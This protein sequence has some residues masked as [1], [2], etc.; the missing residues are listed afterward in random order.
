MSRT[1]PVPNAHGKIRQRPNSRALSRTEPLAGKNL[2]TVLCVLLAG[3]TIA[4]YSPVL[5]HSFVVLD[6]REYV[7]ANSHIHGGLDWN[8]IKWAF[9]SIEAANWHPLTW[10]S[11]ALDYQLFALNPVGHHF[12]SLLIHA[13]NAVLLF[14]LLEWVTKRIGPSL[15]VAALFAL[16]PLNVESVAWVAERKNVLSTLFF[17][18]TIAAYAWYA[19][20]PE[21]RRY[22]LVTALFAA[23]LM[24]KPM[25]IT[26]PF[27]LLLL[28]YWPL[29]RT[30]LDRPESDSATSTAAPRVALSKLVL[31]KIPLLFL[32]AASAWITLIAQRPAKRTLAELPFGIRLEN[33]VVSYG[34]Y[35]WKMLWP[36]RLSLYPHS[37]GALPAWQWILS[38]LVLICIT[39][40]VVSF[41]RQRYLPVGWFWFLGTL[42]PV[43]GLVQVGEYAMA[44]RY[45][46]V[47]LIGIFIMIAWSL[48]DR[49]DAKRVGA[50]WLAIP[51]LCAL[52]A[53]G[54][55]TTRQMTYW[56]SDYDL[57]SHSLEVAETP[58]ALNA[59]GVTLMHPDS[60][61]TQEDRRNFATEQ[62][63][64]AQA[65]QRFER[66]LELRRPLAQQNPGAYLPEMARTL[67]NL[68]N[69]DRLENRMEEARQHGEEA[70]D[71]YRRLA[72]QNPDVYVP[73]LAAALNNLGSLD[74]M[75]NRMEEARQHFEEAVKIDQQ[76]AQQNPNKYLPNLA[77]TL[78]EFGFLDTTQ[79]R[80]E[81]ARQ[82]YEEALKIDRQL[83]GQSPDV[84]LPD[85]AVTLTEFARLNAMQNRMNEARLQFEEALKIHRQLA[86]KDS[87]VYLPDVAMTLSNLG[88]VDQ[89]QNRIE[90]SRVHYTEAMT[91]YQKLAQGD[92][93]R[94][95][96]SVARV[97]ASLRKLEAKASSR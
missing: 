35:L 88:R 6:D 97:E 73:Y 75:Q 95:A 13:L 53:L 2:K 23:G 81:E 72:Q 84:Y 93:V 89:F 12:D 80:M 39:V 94:Y 52:A 96:E 46:Y 60:E 25:V 31:E 67:N 50:V 9:M 49:A 85:L 74:R 16:H 7:T 63:R 78:N 40:F 62:D 27:V 83:V 18:L 20:K 87:A 45:A 1:K 8:T 15:L 5:G 19:Q 68:G 21:W 92:P 76:L 10:L 65:R 30:P 41:R 11:H 58:M 77:M 82:H 55:A 28:D 43:I 32:S 37:V 48:A 69:L 79:N 70:L 61:M 24:A 90:E 44:D 17:F 14:L 56:E 38:A 64:M 91:I 3:V 33:A 36:A 59:L 34:S 71:I 42:V 47:P 51:A 66:A 22:L 86:V 54:F 4:L 26:L 29:E 57:W